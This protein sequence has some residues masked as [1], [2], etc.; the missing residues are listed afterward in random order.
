M[1][2]NP[3]DIEKKYRSLN[4]GARM[5]DVAS[6]LRFYKKGSPKA[7]RFS[8]LLASGSRLPNYQ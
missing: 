6:L 4:T 1:T 8:W 7:F 5:N 3:M 2:I